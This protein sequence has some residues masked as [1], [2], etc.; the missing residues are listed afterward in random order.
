MPGCK[1]GVSQVGQEGGM[2]EGVPE[3]TMLD[4]GSERDRAR[5]Q[6]K[7]APS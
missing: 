4:L 6:V 5:N 1:R 2:E 3:E 7:C